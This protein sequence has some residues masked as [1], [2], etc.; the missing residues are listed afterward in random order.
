MGIASSVI[1][2]V[3]CTECSHRT[4]K[5]VAWLITQHNMHCEQCNEIIDLHAGENAI[6]IEE[7]AEQCT[8]IDDKIG[9]RV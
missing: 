1:Y 8:I 3:A 2:A 7:L 9:T 6:V 5:R 4:P